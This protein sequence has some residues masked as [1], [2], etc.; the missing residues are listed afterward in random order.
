MTE[1]GRS[2]VS[3]VVAAAASLCLLAGCGTTAALPAGPTDAEREAAVQEMLDRQW[4]ATGLEGVFDRPERVP[5]AVVSADIWNG[6]LGDCLGASGIDTWSY[7]DSDGLILESGAQAE[8][9]LQLVWY[10]CLAKYPGV[11]TFSAEQLEYMHGYYTRWLIPCLAYQGY[12]I[13]GSVPAPS[14]LVIGDDPFSSVWNPY[15]AITPNITTQEEY[16]RLGEICP[17]TTPGIEG[18]DDLF[19]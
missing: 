12:R 16:V 7:S 2:V 10:G 3:A 9:T 11:H 13:S 5:T 1:G 6:G 4:V 8:P 17:S 18:W 19:G 14:A 15:F